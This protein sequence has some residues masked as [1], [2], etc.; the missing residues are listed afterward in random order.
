M[1]KR[2]FHKHETSQTISIDY[3]VYREF[4]QT[5]ETHGERR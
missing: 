5:S 3:Q 2:I 1:V 4:S